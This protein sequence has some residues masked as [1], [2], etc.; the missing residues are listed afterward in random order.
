MNGS[1]PLLVGF[2]AVALP[3]LLAGSTAVRADEE[4][5]RQEQDAYGV[6]ATAR[7]GWLG[8]VFS[9]R[10]ERPQPRNPSQFNTANARRSQAMALNIF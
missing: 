4:Q 9:K 6:H 7:P 8:R 3:W 2:C 5:Q 10:Q 1:K